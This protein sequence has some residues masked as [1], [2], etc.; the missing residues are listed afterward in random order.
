MEENYNKDIEKKI[1]VETEWNKD[2]IEAWDIF[3]PKWKLNI[4]KNSNA[5]QLF[6]RQVINVFSILFSVVFG[7]ILF[8]INLK[9]VDNRK[10]I[11]PVILFSIGYTII[12]IFILSL[13]PGRTTVFTL[14]FNAIGAVI[15]YNYL[16]VKYIGGTFKYRTKPFWVPLIIGILISIFLLWII[17][18]GN[19]I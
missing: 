19:Q 1:E 4:V 8:A 6:S 14:I 17:I 9:T 5:P 15:I 18:S 3:S 7:G 12:M 2:E 11:L 13:I 16:W 10:G